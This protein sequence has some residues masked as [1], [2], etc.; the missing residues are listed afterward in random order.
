MLSIRG[1]FS[2]LLLYFLAIDL[3]NSSANSLLEI[4]SF[5]IYLKFFYQKLYQPLEQGLFDIHHI[6]DLQQY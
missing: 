2:F 4:F 3:R 5:L 6:L 1:E